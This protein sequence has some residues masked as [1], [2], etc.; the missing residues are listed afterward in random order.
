MARRDGFAFYDLDTGI[1][2]SGSVTGLLRVVNEVEADLPENRFNDGKCDRP[3]PLLGGLV[4]HPRAPY[5]Q[6][7]AARS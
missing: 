6:P 4:Q 2:Q 7:L 3:R 5:W 1:S